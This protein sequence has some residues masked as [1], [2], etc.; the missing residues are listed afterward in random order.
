MLA[1]SVDIYDGRSFT[2][3]LLPVVALE[4]SLLDVLGKAAALLWQL[5]LIVGPTFEALRFACSRVR[6]ICSDF[7]TESHLANLADALPDF[8][9]MIAPKMPP[10]PCLAFS[11]PRALQVPG[12]KHLW[13]NILSRTLSSLSWFPGWLEHFKALIYFLRSVTMLS[14]L[15]RELRAANQEVLAQMLERAKLPNFAQWRWQTLWRCCEHVRPVLDGLAQHF[16]A[17]GFAN[18]ADA[19][20]IKRVRHALSSTIWMKQFEFVAWVCEWLGQI[21]NFGIGCPCHRFDDPLAATCDRKGR[22]VHQAWIFATSE[23]RRGLSESNNWTIDSWGLDHDFL[24]TVPACIR[25]CFVMA[26]KRISFLDRL[27]YLLLRLREP[28]VAGRCLSQFGLAARLEGHHRVSL[29]YLAPDSPF[30]P[31]IA[32]I[33]P[34]G[35]GI[36]ARL[37]AEIVGLEGCL[38]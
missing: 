23:L 8:W 4:R 26:E 33:L 36:S 31:D 25:A 19:V 35:S 38:F 7:G 2:R 12:W 37:E 29:E 5:W 9:A 14:Q 28:G 24:L 1:T 18:A 27:P 22:R 30:R 32:A 21:M 13:D 3:R 17:A 6:C 16:N 15:L 10:E 11:F 34:D 20:N